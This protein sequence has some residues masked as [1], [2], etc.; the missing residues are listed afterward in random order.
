MVLTPAMNKAH[1]L[2]PARM[3][4]KAAHAI[5]DDERDAFRILNRVRASLTDDNWPAKIAAFRMLY[6]LPVAK[7]VGQIP[8]RDRTLHRRLCQE[9]LRETIEADDAGDLVETVDGLLDLIYVALGWLVQIVPPELVLLS[10]EEVHASN[11]TKVDDCGN[12]VYDEGGKVLKGA[13][14]IK[15]DIGL[16]LGINQ[17]GAS[18]NGEEDRGV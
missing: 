1:D 9:E 8:A 6:N 4:Q 15:A 11:M 2:H 12:P 16:V 13:N 14:Y 10:M 18:D 17:E 5:S 3:P 7:Q